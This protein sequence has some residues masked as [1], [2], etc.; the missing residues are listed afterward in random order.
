MSLFSSKEP[1]R[2]SR[3]P[4]KI[5]KIAAGYHHSAAITVDGELYVWG[6]NANGQLG[7]GKKAEKIIPLPRKIE[8]LDGVAIKM[9]SLGF[10]H[11]IAVTDNG[12]ALSWGGG[13]SGRLGHGHE[14]SI[15]GFQKS[16]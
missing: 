12:E 1:H 6:K 10:E 8:C 4:K 14:S 16:G 5:I 13:E 2:V 15:L 11:S 3:I 9:V 7:L